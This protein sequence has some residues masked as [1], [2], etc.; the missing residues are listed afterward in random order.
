M[1]L[2]SVKIMDANSL[3]AI[4]SVCAAAVAIVASLTTVFVAK[5]VHIVTPP[6]NGA[7][8]A[9]PP[10]VPAV[11]GNPDVGGPSSWPRPLL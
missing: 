1:N 2:Y 9:E 8:A 10:A 5:R 7:P 6:V 11:D 3:A 4:Q